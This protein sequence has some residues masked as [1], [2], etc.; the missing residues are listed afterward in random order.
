MSELATVVALWDTSVYH[1]TCVIQARENLVDAIW[2]DIDFARPLWLVGKSNRDAILLVNVALKVHVC[3]GINQL[4]LSGDEP[5]FDVFFH[6]S[7][8][9]LTIRDLSCQSFDV[10]LN[11][12]LGIVDISLTGRLLEL[13]PGSLRSSVGDVVTIDLASILTT[14]SE[15]T[16]CH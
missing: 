4:S 2:P 7:L 10:F 1:H 12:F 11:R 6:Q 3:E 5:N 13:V 8:L 15:V 16:C 14:V 9:N